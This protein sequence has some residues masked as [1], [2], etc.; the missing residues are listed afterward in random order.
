MTKS[1]KKQ[2]RVSLVISLACVMLAF[3][4]DQLGGFS[5]LEQKTF[6]F[7]VQHRQDQN[8]G[9]EQLVIVLV[10]EAS[11]Q[12]MKGL[13]GR[14][15]W[16]RAVFAELNYFLA[17]LG[18]QA[19]LYD[20]LFT[21][22]QVPRNQDGELGVDD[23]E[24]AVSSM[25]NGHVI[26]ALQFLRELVTE[27][28]ERLLGRPLPKAFV[29]RFAL[30]VEGSTALFE[31]GNNNYYL[32]LPEIYENTAGIGVVE[33]QP[34]NDGVFRRTRLLRSY[35]GELFPVLS[36]AALIH[37]HPENALRIDD[38]TLQWGETAI[39]LLENGEYL[40]NPRNEFETLSIGG[41]F[42][43]IQ[44]IQQG[45]VEDL[46]VDPELFK[47]KIVF[48]GAS[49]VGVEDLKPTPYG[50]NYP[51]VFL[52]A[53]IVSNII[54]QDFIS[55]PSL[56]IEWL[57]SFLIAFIIAWIVTG[58]S[59]SLFKSL[60]PLLITF[61][62]LLFAFYAFS[63]Y[64]VWF[65]V[66]F[67]VAG[68]MLAVYA[69]SFIYMAFTEGAERLRT[70]RMFSQYL[71]PNVLTQV[72]ES[73]SLTAEIGATREI[74]ILFSDIRGF[75]SI[76]E[77]VESRKVVEMLNYYLHEMVD[78]VFNYNGTLDKFI[79][80]AVMAFWGAPIEDEN[81]TGNALLCALE[82][83]EKLKQVN[84][85]FAE[86]D[87]PQIK[88]GV[89]LNTGPVIVGN[90]GSAKRLDYTVIGDNVNLASRIEGLTKNYG[91]AILLTESV[92]HRLEKDI[93]CRI[94]DRVQVKG[95]SKPVILYEPLI[96]PYSSPGRR[97]SLEKA[98]SRS[99]VAFELYLNR[100]WDGAEALYQEVLQELQDD[101]VSQVF[102]ERCREFR[103]QRPP[104]DW[105]GCY[106]YKTK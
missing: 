6:D 104:E 61:L 50:P 41:I 9:N 64:R 44:Q 24:L 92:Y 28:S 73:K 80:D 90:I 74:T 86:N 101:P 59:R 7:R 11:L 40:I 48:I 88:I 29:E 54:E 35:Q 10:D 94:V 85:Y 34:D 17:E 18:A 56:L 55:K 26:H 53:S 4:A 100:D 96:H 89:G 15:P 46:I 2:L 77:T 71:S 31:S 20:V 1:R 27:D 45:T 103:T 87:F 13:V 97:E 60:F 81:H 106:I 62:Y 76:S 33:F 49:A 47:D 42:A 39:P 37:R 22:P 63:L 32:P 14:W 58:K 78:S 51:G 66:V 75:T 23:F 99:N 52:H 16:P 93:V 65:S 84:E 68:G 72:M 70:K 67:P 82:M 83:I 69:A 91:C 43:T 30:E 25:E 57:I 5:F 102:I 98:V 3:L 79:G 19:V 8:K 95:K 38:H 36:L 105:D 12:S 21:E